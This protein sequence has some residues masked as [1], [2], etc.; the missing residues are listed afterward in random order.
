MLA[1]RL[2]LQGDKR[3]LRLD[4]IAVPEPG[5]GQI[6]I[7][8]QAAGVCLSDAH[9]I[10]GTLTPAHLD[11]AIVILGHEVAGTVH[12]LGPGVSGPTIGTRVLLQAGEFR[13]GVP[14]TRGADFDGGWA[15]Y[16]LA[17]VDTVVPIPDSMPFEQACFIPDAVSTSWAAITAT[18][19]VRAA[20]SV[21][22]W[23]AGGLGAHAIQLLHLVG[24]APII[25]IDPLEAARDRALQFG[26]DLALDPA[27]PTVRDQILA[28]TGGR[29]IT[30]AFDFAGVDPVRTQAL[31][32]L[33]PGGRL[34]LVGLTGR[35]ITITDSS[36]FCSFQNQV[37]GHFGSKPEHI[38]ELVTLYGANRV[39]FS[40]SVSS[41]VPLADAAKAV[42]SLETKQGNPIRIILK[43]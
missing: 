31:T 33:A 38:V 22:V 8:V 25:A 30:A 1:A 34:I 41:I 14:Y 17:S 42:Q 12:S 3:E 26:A 9:L 37:R 28:N 13:N 18:A 19:A 10:D 21:G 43:P 23:G 16:A 36:L 5:V 7:K 29:G 2:H 11:S 27:D 6:L 39:E 24:A 35:P 40:R 15:E 20:E 32:C 4:D